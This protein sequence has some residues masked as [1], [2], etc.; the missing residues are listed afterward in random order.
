ML[1]SRLNPPLVAL[2]DSDQ[3]F[4]PAMAEHARAAS[5]GSGLAAPSRGGGSMRGLFGGRSGTTSGTLFVTDK[6]GLTPARAAVAVEAA[7]SA[8]KNR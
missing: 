1:H 2:L 3:A 5:D 7:M 6:S 4:S 8:V